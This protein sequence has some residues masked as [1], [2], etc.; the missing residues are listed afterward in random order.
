VSEPEFEPVELGP[1]SVAREEAPI[2]EQSLVNDIPN[3]STILSGALA[4]KLL[5]VVGGIVSLACLLLPACNRDHSSPSDLLDHKKVDVAQQAR[6]L[7]VVNHLRGDFNDEAC[8]S[9]Y[10]A[11]AG[12]FKAEEFGDWLDDCHQMKNDLGFWSSF[13]F[14][15][16]MRCGKPEFVVCLIGSGEFERDRTEVRIAVQLNAEGDQLHTLSIQGRDRRW[17]QIPHWSSGIPRRLSDPPRKKS[18]KDGLAS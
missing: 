15:S 7:A 10:N 1:V 9:I 2:A 12:F 4:M 18:P 16:A 5:R 11:A 17:W 13:G 6:A 3:R 14:E 8:Q